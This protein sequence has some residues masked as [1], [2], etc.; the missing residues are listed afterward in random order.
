MTRSLLPGAAHAAH[1]NVIDLEP[2]SQL[3]Q[4]R[5][6]PFELE[7]RVAGGDPQAFHLGQGDDDVFGDAVAEE[8][9]F[10]VSIHVD[11]RQYG[12]GRCGRLGSARCKSRGGTGLPTAA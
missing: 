4:I 8:L 1:E 12:D 6:F 3:F 11:E 9:A 10:L 7:G 5:N 2:A